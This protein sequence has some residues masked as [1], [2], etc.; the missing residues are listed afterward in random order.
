MNKCNGCT[1][2]SKVGI[3]NFQ[4]C[5]RCEHNPFVIADRFNARKPIIVPQKAGEVWKKSCDRF[6]YMITEAMGNELMATPS[7]NALLTFS[8]EK[9]GSKMIHGENGWTRLFHLKEDNET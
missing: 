4:T 1:H 6:V 2:K 3:Y 5:I 8:I 7:N 9:H